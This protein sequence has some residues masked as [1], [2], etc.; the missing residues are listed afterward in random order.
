MKW[1]HT[2]KWFGRVT[3]T[4]LYSTLRP[5]ASYVR[6]IFLASYIPYSLSL[7]QLIKICRDRL[8]KDTYELTIH[9]HPPIKRYITY[10]V[11]KK[12]FY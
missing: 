6:D 11:P 9:Y 12:K 1:F 2:D 8:D 3:G 10:A 7:R 4:P 5:R